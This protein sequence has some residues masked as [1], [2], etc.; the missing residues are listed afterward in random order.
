M[1]NVL[2]L[3]APIIQLKTIGSNS[4][5]G[6]NTSFTTKNDTIIATL[7]IGYADGYSRI[8]SNCGEVFIDGHIAPV[9]GK[10]SMDLV[11]IDVTN[12][13]PHK[14][15]LGQ[16]VEIINDYC[17]IDKIASIIGGIGYEILTLLHGPR[18]KRIYK[19]DTE[20]S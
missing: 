6:Y 12:I 19:N 7:P 2:N 18:F 8:F 9:I 15:F 3:T 5:V 1:Q 17:T 13:P 11:T 20:L 14:I 10:V 4:H 16:K